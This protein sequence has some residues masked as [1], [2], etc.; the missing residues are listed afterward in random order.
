[1]EVQRLFIKF[2]LPFVMVLIPIG[3]QKKLQRFHPILPLPGFVLLPVCDGV[4]GERETAEKMHRNGCTIA[5][6]AGMGVSEVPH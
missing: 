1:M 6:A 4:G 5:E 2:T 3:W